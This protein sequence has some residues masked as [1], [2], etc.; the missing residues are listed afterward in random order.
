MK[1]NDAYSHNLSLHDEQPSWEYSQQAIDLTSGDQARPR[2]R[3]R[4]H[5]RRTIEE[6][7]EEKPLGSRKADPRS[8]GIPSDQKM[9]TPI[10]GPSF[11]PP[12]SASL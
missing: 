2:A 4:Q 7:I 1:G 12:K 8:K 3:H 10:R 5:A 11:V 6:E 9:P